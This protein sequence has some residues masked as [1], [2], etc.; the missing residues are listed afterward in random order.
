MWSWKSQQMGLALRWGVEGSKGSG[1]P[2]LKFAFQMFQATILVNWGFID[3]PKGGVVVVHI[4]I[5]MLQDIVEHVHSVPCRWGTEF[6]NWS[7][8]SLNLVQFS[9]HRAHMAKLLLSDIILT[10]LIWQRCSRLLHRVG[11]YNYPSE[12][13]TV[14]LFFFLVL[15]F[16]Y[17]D[18]SNW[19]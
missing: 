2:W 19:I 10:A 4:S 3:P 14:A 12:D 1:L 15:L 16:I 18:L 11:C 6:C 17:R 7:Y 5:L 13:V 8:T 9:Q